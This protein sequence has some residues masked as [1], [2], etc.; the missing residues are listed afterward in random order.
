MSRK[1]DPIVAVTRFFS[2]APIEVATAALAI[3]RDVVRKRTEPAKPPAKPRRRVQKPHAT[4]TEVSTSAPAVSVSQPSAPPAAS[5]TPTLPTAVEQT[6]ARRR[7]AVAGTL[8]TPS[9]QQQRPDASDLAL[10]GLG[11]STVGE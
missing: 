10:P 6:K 9:V 7:R 4:P 5:G 2:D 8:A 3:A 11:P 1:Q